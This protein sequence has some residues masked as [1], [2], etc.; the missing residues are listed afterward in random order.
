MY[1]TFENLEQS[2]KDRI[3]QVCIEE[4][5][6]NGYEKASTNTIV[7]RLGISKGLLFL[8]FKSKKNLFLY[9]VEHIS[10]SLTD[11]FLKSFAADGALSL[12][13]FDNLGEFYF[14]IFREKPDTFLFMLEALLISQPEL[15]EE[16]DSRHGL[17]HEYILEKI[18]MDN[19]RKDVEPQMIIDLLH[20]VSYHVGLMV[21]KDYKPGEDD[22][23]ESVSRYA[24]TYNLY[25]DI[26]KHGIYLRG[27]A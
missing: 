27:Q 7:K 23:R 8:Y 11:E 17:A 24:E 22:L 21:F 10:R 18:N 6:R 12:N 14:K 5:A 26:I 4:F 13:E 19:I 25:I 1:K 2:R 3:L 9:L 20:M 15:R 16:I